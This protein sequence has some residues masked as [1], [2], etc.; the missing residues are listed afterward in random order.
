MEQLTQNEKLEKHFLSN[1]GE[2]ID[3]PVLALVI[4][5]TGIGAAVHSRVSDLR[6]KRG[7]HIEHKNSFV[8]EDGKQ[9]CLSRYRYLPCGSAAATT[10]QGK[11]EAQ[12]E[13]KPCPSAPKADYAQPAQEELGV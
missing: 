6:T 2:W 4:T 11:P 12:T 9:F 10:A 13:P 7:L 3:M 5:E 8:T 1:P